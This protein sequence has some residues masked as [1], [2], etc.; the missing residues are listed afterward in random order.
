[1]ATTMAGKS[2]IGYSVFMLAWFLARLFLGDRI[3]WLMLLNRY[4]IYLFIPILIFVLWAG[5]KRQFKPLIPLLIPVAL[6][7]FLYYPYLIP[8]FNQTP[9]STGIQLRVMTYNVLFSNFDYDAVAK[10]VL[11]DQHDLVALQEVQPE[12]MDALKERLQDQYPF[13][14]MGNQNN[15]G[16]TAVFSRH[17]FSE[18]YVLN[19]EVDRPAVVIKTEIDGQQITFVSAHLLA[20]GFRWIRIVDFPRVVMER[21]AEQNRQVEIILN[22]LAEETNSV[23]LACDCNTYETASSYRLL[24]DWLTNSTRSAGWNPLQPKPAGVHVDNDLRH[25]DYIWFRGAL[26]PVGVYTVTDT[27]GSDHRPVI[28]NFTFE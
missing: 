28:A 16:T 17:P 9:E 22:D 23:I 26:S 25:I 2:T 24:E 12:M 20:Y 14:I 10:V 19:L 5:F 1:M 13:S 11:A 27:G 3:W 18:S 8:K 6:F 7:S 15:F 21:T 4:V